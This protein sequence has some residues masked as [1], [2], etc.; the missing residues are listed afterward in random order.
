MET[1]PDLTKLTE[2]DKDALIIALYKIIE[3]LRLQVQQQADEIAKLK[4]Q[5]NKNSQNSSKP[6]SSDGLS[7]PA[8]KSLRKSSQKKAGGQ[9]GHKGYHL[10]AVS[11]ADHITHHVVSHCEACH[12][13][14]EA[15]GAESYEE[16][17]VF[18]IPVPR[19][20]VTAHRAEKKRCPCGHLT[21]APFPVTVTSSVQYGEQIKGVAVYFNQYQLLPY[22]RCI[23][24]LEDLYG[25]RLCEGSLLNFNEQTY[26]SLA[27]TE[28]QI[29]AALQQAAVLNVDESGIRVEGKLHWVHSASTDQ[30]T[31]YHSH[32]KRGHEAM[33]EIGLLPNYTGKLVHDHF[34]A[35]FRYTQCLHGACNSH[36]LREL[37]FL[38]ENNQLHWAGEMVRLLVTIKRTVDRAKHQHRTE[39]NPKLQ[40]LFSQRYDDLIE[41]GLRQDACL[42]VTRLQPEIPKK[43]GRKKQSKAKNL[44]D[45]LENYKAD[46]L[47]FMTDFSVPF[48]NNQAERDIRMVKLKQKVSGTFRSQQGAKI[49]FRIRGYLSSAKKQG[50]KM[51]EALTCCFQNCPLILA[52]AE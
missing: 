4:A 51:L 16:R 3:D 21:T 25:A 40:Q 27:V 1:R 30:L 14:L 42:E 28:S 44:L 9:K 8:P 38:V 19:I 32:P 12:N 5:L 23:E 20:Q 36:H 41:A 46:T 45:R 33:D 34:K 13:N 6:P 31:F 18:D 47:R 37:V 43:R 7:K 11:N 35:Y 2:L 39:L 52:G 17:Q 48:D 50:H 15:T 49:F 10:E 22:S 24:A 26:A 29:K